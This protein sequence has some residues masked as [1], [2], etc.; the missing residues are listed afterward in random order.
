MVWLES[1]LATWGRWC[2]WTHSALRVCPAQGLAGLRGVPE[3]SPLQLQLHTPDLAPSQ[4][5]LLRV[6]S[7]YVTIPLTDPPGGPTCQPP[8]LPGWRRKNL[9]LTQMGPTRDLGSA[10]AVPQQP[11]ACLD[12]R[13][14]SAC[15]Q[16]CSVF[17]LR[18]RE[19]RG[20]FWDQQIPKQL[21]SCG[22]VW[23]LSGRPQNKGLR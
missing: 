10:T 3:V 9:K 18:E 17:L 11:R 2:L 1:V 20:S 14:L 21:F 12:T 4:R 7:D 22:S 15:A 16:H 19:S 23:T 13:G 5:Q 6:Q 8:S